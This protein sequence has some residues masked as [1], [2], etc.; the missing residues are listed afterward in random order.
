MSSSRSVTSGVAAE[1][2]GPFDCII[3]GGGPAGLTAATF[4]ARFRR[5][6]LVVDA[7]H[8]RARWIP[9][10][11]N[12][13]AFPDGIAGERLLERLRVQ[14]GEYGPLPVPGEVQRISRADDGVFRLVSGEH[15]WTTRY[16]LLATGVVDRLPSIEGVEEAMRSGLVRQC[17]ICD[18]YEIIDRRIV[19][20][21]HNS[22]AL[23]E[24]LFLRTYTTDLTL[25]TL[26]R[27][28]QIS[29]DDMVSLRRAG[30]QVIET[31]L[32]RATLQPNRPVQLAFLDGTALE[33]DAAYSALG[34]DPQ[35][36]LAAGL[37]LPVFGDGRIST[38]PHQ[39]TEV[40]GCYAAGDIVTGLN[41]IAVAMAQG[42]IAA[43]DIHNRL[44]RQEGLALTG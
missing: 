39:E 15:Q 28:L 34:V 42:E 19:I 13:P 26:G 10:S 27:P 1:R 2:H 3:V 41:Q 20:F 40:P 31:P 18:G 5:R 43:V 12:H 33:F 7:G 30:L 9:R 22:L 11:H 44:R 16:L 21:G 4:L 25:A 6:A 38:S 35:N 36:A 17:P 23:A 37:G 24:A 29:E 14:L 32:H 8:S